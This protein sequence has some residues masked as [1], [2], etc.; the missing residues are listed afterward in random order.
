MSTK[1]LAKASLSILFLF[2]VTCCFAQRGIYEIKYKFYEKDQS[3]NQQLGQEYSSL[4]FYY[5]LNSASNVMRTRYYDAK[6]GWTVVEQR[7]KMSLSTE[8]NKNYWLLAG[9]DA[10][11]ITTVSQGAQYNP[12]NIVLSKN[13]SET[14]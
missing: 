5:D 1:L 11:F 6:D 14:Y 3:G 10:K 7:I 9:Q 13:P 12:D 4:I 8:N 2:V